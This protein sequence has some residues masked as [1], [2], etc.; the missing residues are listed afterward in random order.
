M[1]RWERG[2]RRNKGKCF[3][4]TSR[5]GERPGEESLLCK[6]RSPSSD[7]Q[8]PCE[9]GHGSTA[10][11]ADVPRSGIPSGVRAPRELLFTSKAQNNRHKNVLE[12]GIVG[13]SEA[14]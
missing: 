2:G 12:T 3:K 11:D 1:E 8:H 6:H 9:A 14:R 13:V 7:P 10:Q 5:A 4:F